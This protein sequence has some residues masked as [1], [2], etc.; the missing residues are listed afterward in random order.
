[1]DGGVLHMINEPV[2]YMLAAPCQ[3]KHQR[4]VLLNDS[5]EVITLHV[6]QRLQPTQKSRQQTDRIKFDDELEKKYEYW[7]TYDQHTAGLHDRKQNGTLNNKSIAEEIAS[8]FGGSTACKIMIDNVMWALWNTMS[9][10]W[11]KT[12]IKT[13][14][15]ITKL[16]LWQKTWKVSWMWL[17][18][19]PTNPTQKNGIW[20]RGVVP[21]VG[22]ILCHPDEVI[23]FANT[24]QSMA[25]AASQ[26]PYKQGRQKYQCKMVKCSI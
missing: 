9:H 6:L 10:S 16:M 23:L 8:S 14:I 17:T 26:A 20:G 13:Y 2:K 18:R 21:L 12:A 5:Q 22:M 4:V 24:A 19:L 1:M 7:S 15:T 11:H 25:S 3:S